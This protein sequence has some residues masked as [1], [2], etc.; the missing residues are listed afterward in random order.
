MREIIKQ[1]DQQKNE[2]GDILRRIY[3]QIVCV[4][5]TVSLLF[6]SCA[7]ANENP[8]KNA[9]VSETVTQENNSFP[10]KTVDDVAESESE[11]ESEK[12]SEKASDNTGTNNTQ[13]TKET[14]IKTEK[15][16]KITSKEALLKEL[17]KELSKKKFSER[18]N[19][20]LRDVLDRLYKYYPEWQ[21]VFKDMPSADKYIRQNF[22]GAIKY[23]NS[24]NIID[25]DSPEGKE[26]IDD[27]SA[28]AYIVEGND[29]TLY[30]FKGS[31]DVYNDNLER[32]YHEVTHCRQRMVFDDSYFEGNEMFKKVI[33]EGGATFHMKFIR[34]NTSEMGGGGLITKGD[35]SETELNYYN[36]NGEGYSF[37]RN[38]YEHLIYMA[39]YDCINKMEMKKISLSDVKKQISRNY[40]SETAD[41]IWKELKYFLKIY[42]ENFEDEK[43]FNEAVKLQKI[44]LNFVKTDI[45]NLNTKKPAQVRKFM[46]VYRSYKLRM[47]AKWQERIGS[48]LVVISDE[49]FNIDYYDNLMIQKIIGAG[50]VHFSSDS[51]LNRM[52]VKALIFASNEYFYSVETQMGDYIPEDLETA[53]YTY[54]EYKN[55]GELIITDKSNRIK[56][57]FNRTKI[58]IED[59]NAV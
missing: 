53:K 37:E 25:A 41:T 31:G 30:Y 57:P 10:D 17:N 8:T 16:K 49:K 27:G 50:V 5:I 26:A 28:F 29:L 55:S 1:K 6:S 33:V 59:I 18:A 11:E 3:F 34:K 4:L 52:A 13:K 12:S 39:G 44:F 23:I 56:I 51:S 21:H 35:D 54:K 22:I 7:K 19:N 48:R 32:L 36:N 46:N 43:V 2:A 9:D 38:M 45:E 15:T 20:L 24:M 47:L 42:N 40:G 14:V 58:I